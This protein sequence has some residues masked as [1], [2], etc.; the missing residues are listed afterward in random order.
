MLKHPDTVTFDPTN[1]EHQ[2]A[3]AMLTLYNKQHPTLRFTLQDQSSNIPHEL[4]RAFIQH[5]LDD[6]V[7]NRLHEVVTT[8]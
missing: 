6:E 1:V 8:K 5:H 2:V 4:T 3:L 7:K